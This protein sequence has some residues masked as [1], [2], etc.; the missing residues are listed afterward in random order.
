MIAPRPSLVFHAV[1]VRVNPLVLGVLF[2]IIGVR[3][4]L[5]FKPQQLF[6]GRFVVCPFLVYESFY[7]IVLRLKTEHKELIVKKLVA[8]VNDNHRFGCA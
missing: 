4:D 1:A 5:V 7:H 3:N 6:Y 2:K 8:L